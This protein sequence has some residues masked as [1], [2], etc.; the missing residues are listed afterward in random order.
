M[1]E[2]DGLLDPNVAV[3]AALARLE[4]RMDSGFREV[5]A[6]IGEVRGD[7]VGLRGE[8][9]ELRTDVGGLRGE[10]G[11]LRLGLQDL[12]TEVREGHQALEAGQKAAEASILKELRGTRA[13]MGTELAGYDE[14]LKRLERPK[15]TGT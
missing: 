2:K 13:E 3:L 12:R 5:R 7:V 1:G 9:G 8:V 14:R 6:E 10:V 11:D 4:A 15:R